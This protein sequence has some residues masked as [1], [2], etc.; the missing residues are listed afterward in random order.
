MAITA[1]INYISKVGDNSV[2]VGVTFSDGTIREF[3]LPIDSDRP[4]IRAEVRSEVAR[5][6][7]LEGKVQNLQALV[8]QVIS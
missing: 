3:N 6:N 2:G 4:T 7:S 5:L 8:G 1:T